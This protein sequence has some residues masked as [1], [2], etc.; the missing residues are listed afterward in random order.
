[1]PQY[2]EYMVEGHYLYFTSECIVEAIH[3][4]ASDKKLTRYRSAK[5]WILE[6]N[7]ES[8]L[9]HRIYLPE[10]CCQKYQYQT[11]DQQRRWNHGYFRLSKGNRADFQEHLQLHE[12]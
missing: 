1:M 12:F 5:F 8:C 3:A 11:A 10:S 7:S 4:H 6:Y 9:F 2:T